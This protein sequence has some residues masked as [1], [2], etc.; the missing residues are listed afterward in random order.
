MLSALMRVIPP[1]AYLTMPCVGLDIS[2]ASLKYVAF[3]PTLRT[4]C[5][6]E[7]TLWGDI[8]I[9]TGVVSRGEVLDTQK[10]VAVLKEFKN[11]TKAEFVRMS[12]PEERAYSFETEI[13]TNTPI[14][15]IRGLLEFRLEENV[16][17]PSRDVYFDYSIMPFEVGDRV[18]RVSVV[19]YAKQ[20]IQSYYD[21]CMEAGLR[22]ISFEVEAQA[23]ARAVVPAD[24]S[25]ATLIVDFGKTRTGIGIVYKGALLYTSTIDFGGAHLSQVLRK[26]LGDKSETE[27]TSIKNTEGL[28]RGVESSAVRD[29]LMSTVSVIR[30]EIVR[31]MQYWNIRSVS[32]DDR[33]ITSVILCGGSANLKGLPEYMCETLGVQTV[34]GNVWENAF[35]L[36]DTVP[37]IDRPHSF[38]YAAAIGLALKSIL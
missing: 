21:A 30:D 20:T 37:P 11:K 26:V 19:A 8:D 27:L 9:P 28:V 32:Q 6:R 10:L 35:S 17:I 3:K 15:E 1:P 5:A 29:A 38:G 14:K 22:P 23:M 24:I 4:P 12:L 31:H 33:R 7:L 34:R 25:G 16:P 13:K 36:E 2:D 18:L